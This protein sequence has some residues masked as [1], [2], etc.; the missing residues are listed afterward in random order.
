MRDMSCGS[1]VVPRTHYMSYLVYTLQWVLLKVFQQQQQLY[2][3]DTLTMLVLHTTH[4]DSAH[5]P[6]KLMHVNNEEE[7]GQ[8]I[9]CVCGVYNKCDSLATM[10]PYIINKYITRKERTSMCRLTSS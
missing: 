6:D 3:L 7:E 10:R 2:I 8:S 1:V 4:S 9:N 5:A